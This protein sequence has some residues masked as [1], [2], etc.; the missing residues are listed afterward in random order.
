MKRSDSAATS[1]AEAAGHS[2][3]EGAGRGWIERLWPWWAEV[4]GSS[5]KAD[6]LAGLLGALLVLPQGI[7]FAALA[8]LPPQYGLYSALVPTVV[9]ALGGSSR[10]VVS[11]PTNANSLALAAMILPLA[12]AGTPEYIELALMVTLMVGVLQ[13]CVGGLRLGSWAHFISPAVLL[14]FTSGAACLIALHALRELLDAGWATGLGPWKMLAM[15]PQSWPNISGPAV[16][17]GLGTW[18]L[19]VALRRWRPGWP[20]ML[21]ALALMTAVSVWVPWSR[22]LHTVGALPSPWPDWHVPQVEWA[23]L[24]LLFD[25][26]LALSLVALGQSVSIAKAVALRSGQRVD[27]NREFVGQGLANV[28]GSLASAYLSCGSLNRS[29]PN[30]EAGARTPLA[31]VASAGWLLLLV[32]LSGPMLALIPHAAVSGLLLMVAWSLLDLP[33]W[34]RLKA[35]AP[36]EF[37]IAVTTGLAA[38]V[39]HLESAILL[40]VGLS[41]LVHLHETSRPALRLMGFD[42]MRPDRPFVVRADARDPLPEC[43]QLALLRMEGSIYFGAATHV[44]DRLHELR[45]QR[46][47]QTHLL[48]MAKSMNFL[49]LAGAEVWE[50]ELRERRAAGGDLH[51]HRPRPQV[52]AFWRRTGFLGRL[53]EQNVHD[54][55]QA[56]LGHI[57]RRLDP[58]VCAACQARVFW[59]CRDDDPGAA[60]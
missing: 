8:G 53:G 22:P 52:M 12:A 58:K 23:M 32:L 49:D 44:G 29:L 3:A 48:V 21:I 60:I 51:F 46:P 56:A 14:G 11:G 18:A 19:A 16:G 40:G 38:L 20:V 24:P 50:H 25:K 17:I 26:A 35:W 15:L 9:A 45:A 41:L 7:A 4:S 1:G 47:G 55:K 59:E 10:H 54:S 37:A 42:S 2:R 34:R 27:T 13:V 31:A 30:L 28:T 33:R 5:L 39:L 43:P 6:V 36:V 57:V